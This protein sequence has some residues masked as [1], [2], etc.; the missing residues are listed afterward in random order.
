MS[1]AALTFLGHAAFRVDTPAGLA[2]Y[3]DPWL[4]N[5]LCPPDQRQPDRVDVIALTHGHGDHLGQTVELWERF[6]PR[7]IAPGEL[8]ATL[9]GAGV[10]PDSVS[11]PNIGGSVVVADVR[12]T[13]TVANHS[14]SGPEGEYTGSPAGLVMSIA[15]GATLYFAGDTNVFGD[16]SLIR[17]IYQP[18]IAC[19]P[20]GDY[21]TM[22]PREA[23]KALELL[24]PRQCVPCHYGTLPDLTGTPDQLADFLAPGLETELVV[25]EP[26]TTMSVA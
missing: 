15:D 6:K 3:V 9:A 8:G 17:E 10:A 2:I 11:G 5:P 19:L 14:S 18:T 7:V 20:I 21:Y 13:L 16:M 25:L 4:E 23:A 24:R 12:V 22:G 1:Q 26:G